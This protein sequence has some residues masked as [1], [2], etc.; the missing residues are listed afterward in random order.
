M[1][2]VNNF[3]RGHAGKFLYESSFYKGGYEVAT[4]Y[5]LPH[6]KVSLKVDQ[7]A[8]VMSHGFVIR[9]SLSLKFDTD[10][11][12]IDYLNREIAEIIDPNSYFL[13]IKNTITGDTVEEETEINNFYEFVDY[14][15][16]TSSVDHFLEMVQ[17][18]Y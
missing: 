17:E 1:K 14:M 9:G 3:K 13:E 11:H 18:Y 12:F 10:E 16:K 6:I 4:C 7:D 15:F 5:V 8:V 2:I